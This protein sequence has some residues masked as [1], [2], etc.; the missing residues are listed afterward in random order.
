MMKSDHKHISGWFLSQPNGTQYPSP[1]LL[2]EYI[3]I[4]SILIRPRKW[5]RSTT[6]FNQQAEYS[7]AKRERERERRTYIQKSRA[8]L[9]LATTSGD[10][11]ISLSLTLLRWRRISANET[12]Y[13][14]Q[15]EIKETLRE[16]CVLWRDLC[17]YVCAY[18]LAIWLPPHPSESLSLSLSFWSSGIFR[19]SEKFG[20]RL[21]CRRWMV[22]WMVYR[23][24]YING[25]REDLWLYTAAIYCELM[26]AWYI[27]LSAEVVE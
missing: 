25:S 5:R 20:A 13:F 6:A 1:Q 26:S 12:L 19:C 3:C 16:S 27:V 14:G 18:S 2:F 24:E 8:L 10:S 22:C 11:R 21:S 17:V 9:L 23:D 4:Y 7:C 15:T